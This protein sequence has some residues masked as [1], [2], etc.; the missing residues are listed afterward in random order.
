MLSTAKHLRPS[1]RRRRALKMIRDSSPATADQNDKGCI[2][3]RRFNEVN[4]ITSI[5]PFVPGTGIV[6]NRNCPAYKSLR[7]SGA[8]LVGAR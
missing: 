6:R 8:A 5:S 3:V 4:Q 2:P 1:A 7:R